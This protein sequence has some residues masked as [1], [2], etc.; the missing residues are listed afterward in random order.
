LGELLPSCQVIGGCVGFLRQV[1]NG[2]FDLI[3]N[4]NRWMPLRQ[5]GRPIASIVS[6]CGW[7]VAPGHRRGRLR[8]PDA[9][10]ACAATDDGDRQTD[11]QRCVALQRERQAATAD[12]RIWQ[13][14]AAFDAKVCAAQYR[15]AAVGAKTFRH[16]RY[17]TTRTAN[18]NA[19]NG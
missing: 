3:R 1:A 13:P 6:A 7:S 10:D 19:E 4:G 9:D 15:G 17:L 2:L 12:G 5:V 16:T 11:Q 14:F 8:A 18:C